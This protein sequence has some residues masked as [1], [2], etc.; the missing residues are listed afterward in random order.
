MNRMI[1]TLMALML[2]VASLGMPGDLQTQNAMAADNEM[3]YLA[4]A[5]VR[6]HLVDDEKSIMQLID[7]RDCTY[8]G[9]FMVFFVR[10]LSAKKLMAMFG[11]PVVFFPEEKIILVLM[12]QEA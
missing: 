12:D 8:A 6:S 1:A 9:D 11:A 7:K 5:S 2:M 3:S 4:T 10:G